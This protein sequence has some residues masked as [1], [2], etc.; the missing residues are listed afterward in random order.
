MYLYALVIERWSALQSSLLLQDLMISKS[1]IF[2][3]TLAALISGAVPTMLAPKIIVDNDWSPV[4]FITFP[5]AVDARWDTS[6]W[7]AIKR[8]LGRARPYQIWELLHGSP[9]YVKLPIDSLAKLVYCV[10][11]ET[12]AAWMVEQVRKYPGEITI[13]SG[14]A[15]TNVALAVRLDPEFA[16]LAKGLA[17]MGGETRLL[18]DSNSDAV[19]GNGVN[20]AFTVLKYLN[21]VY[22]IKTPFTELFHKSYSTR[23]PFWDEISSPYYGN[24]MVYQELLMPKLQKLQKVQYV[25][26]VNETVFKSALKRAMECPRRA[27]LYA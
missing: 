26:E 19:V 20:Q 16:S 9:P 5:L 23:P 3:G 12:A 22:E 7:S 17:I 27:T 10:A 6:A 1:V 4:G 21:E 25:N 2:L 15:L 24:I 8:T 13:Y 11:G 14:G 18:A